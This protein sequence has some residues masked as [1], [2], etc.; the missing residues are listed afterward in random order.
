MLTST[1]K[2]FCTYATPGPPAPCDWIV[3]GWRLASP[4]GWL[5]PV[6]LNWCWCW[7][8]CCTFC[9]LAAR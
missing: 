6:P 9:W 7:C 2:N 8:W 1:G 5:L 4:F 3:T